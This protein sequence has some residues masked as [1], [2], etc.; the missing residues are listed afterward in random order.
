MQFFLCCNPISDKSF[1]SQLKI[2][3]MKTFKNIVTEGLSGRIKQLVFRQWQGQTVVASAPSPS[4]IPATAG[5]QLTRVTFREAA[6]YAKAVLTDTVIKLAYKAKTK[7]GQS[8]YNLAIADFFKPPTIGN[9][10]ASA[11]TARAGSFITAQVTDD[12]Q[13]ASVEVRFENASGQLVEAGAAVLMEDGLHYR[14]TT[15]AAVANITGN[16]IT[17]IATDLPGHLVTKQTI[18]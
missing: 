9:I 7:R 1:I 4:S 15:T 16:K 5:Q 17:F 12:F 2:T 11:Y 3:V 8:P 6:I 13:V 10:D 18:L 14:Y